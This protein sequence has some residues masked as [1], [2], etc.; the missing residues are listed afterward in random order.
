MHFGLMSKNL[1]GEW[2]GGLTGL[3]VLGREQPAGLGQEM[4]GGYLQQ[5]QL[6]C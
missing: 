6:S 4:E 1:L 2:A 3:L 5:P